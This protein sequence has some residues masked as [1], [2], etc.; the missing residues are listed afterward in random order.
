MKIPTASL[1]AGVAC[2]VLLVSP[3][4]IAD[5][6]LAAG[7]S[8]RLTANAHLNF[9][10]I[11]PG[12]LS[13]RMLDAANSASGTPLVDIGSNGRTVALASTFAGSI[14]RRDSIIGARFRGGV[15]V[16]TACATDAHGASRMTCTVSCP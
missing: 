15:A 4:A 6:Q 7:E 9:R 3:L 8:G 10:I 11:I 14:R 16:Q 5:G 2:A 12:V 13:L 1:C